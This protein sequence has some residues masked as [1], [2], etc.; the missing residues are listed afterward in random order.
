MEGHK[1]ELANMTPD[2]SLQSCPLRHHLVSFLA[3]GRGGVRKELLELRQRA[4]AQQNSLMV[5][6]RVKQGES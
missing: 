4:G 5:I 2:L 6:E 1:T 3:P